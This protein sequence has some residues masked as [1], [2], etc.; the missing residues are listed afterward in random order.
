MNNKQELE[1]PLIDEDNKSLQEDGY[2]I[3]NFT[4]KNRR[5]GTL[6]HEDGHIKSWQNAGITQMNDKEWEKKMHSKYQE[7]EDYV[8]QYLT[9]GNANADDQIETPVLCEAIAEDYRCN[10][11]SIANTLPH[12]HFYHEDRQDPKFKEMRWKLLKESGL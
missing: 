10:Y 5:A 8:M 2:D 7:Y 3:T 1:T 9:D 6:I 11:N 4:W 12:S